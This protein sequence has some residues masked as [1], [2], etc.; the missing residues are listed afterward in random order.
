MT[1]NEVVV[2]LLKPA[3]EK[4]A[5]SCFQIHQTSDNK[6]ADAGKT[7]ADFVNAFTQA[8]ALDN[9]LEAQDSP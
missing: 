2:E 7:T 4:I 5:S 6:A 3:M 1:K 9:D 8:L